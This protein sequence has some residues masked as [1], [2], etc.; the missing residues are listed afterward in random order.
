MRSSWHYAAAVLYDLS[1][2]ISRMIM[3]IM[4]PKIDS[5]IDC[6]HD[7]Q[8]ILNQRIKATPYIPVQ[9]LLECS[10]T[11]WEEACGEICR[12]LKLN[13]LVTFHAPTHMATIVKD[14]EW[15]IKGV[16]INVYQLY[17]PKT[18]FFSD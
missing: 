16:N 2:A 13:Y 14:M 18:R 8:F 9:L 5:S 10:R 7:T 15:F 3:R 1:K 11:M 4:M 12:F 17:V 6:P